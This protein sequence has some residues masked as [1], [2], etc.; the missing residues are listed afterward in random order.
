MR[1][2]SGILSLVIVIKINKQKHLPLPF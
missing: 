2:E 1:Y